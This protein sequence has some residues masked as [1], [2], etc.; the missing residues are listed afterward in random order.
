MPTEL[1]YRSILPFNNVLDIGERSLMKSGIHLA[2][3]AH[4]AWRDE[5]GSQRVQEARVAPHE[6][7][8][9]RDLL[10]GR[11]LRVQGVLQRAFLELHADAPAQHRKA[12]GVVWF[13]AREGPETPRGARGVKSEAGALKKVRVAFARVYV[14]ACAV[15]KNG[16]Q[17][18]ALLEGARRVGGLRCGG[19]RPRRR[20]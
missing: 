3:P 17:V 19:R 6:P 5:R 2:T 12:A 16:R 11:C 14:S 18:L 9:E 8:A 13:A 4:Q 15:R 10:C 1:Y 7:G 20:G